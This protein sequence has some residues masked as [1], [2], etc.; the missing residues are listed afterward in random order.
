MS[1]S[2]DGFLPPEPEDHE[3]DGWEMDIVPSLKKE[4]D[5]EFWIALERYSTPLPILGTGGFLILEFADNTTVEEA[6]AVEQVLQTYIAR[7]VYCGPI[8]K[9]FSDQLGRR[10]V[11]RALQPKRHRD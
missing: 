4:Q 8:E 6:E 9:R 10:G 11:W 2:T 5:G 3:I 1:N 7:V